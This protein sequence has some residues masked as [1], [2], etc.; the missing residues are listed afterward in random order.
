MTQIELWKQKK[1]QEI[2]DMDTTQV[3]EEISWLPDVF[4]FNSKACEY[5][6]YKDVEPCKS[7]CELGIKTYLESEVQTNG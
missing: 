6:A 5:C 1:I 2:K 7:K 3:I 4:K